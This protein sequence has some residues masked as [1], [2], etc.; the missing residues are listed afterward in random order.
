[1]QSVYSIVPTN[2]VGY[3][4]LLWNPT[5]GWGNLSWSIHCLLHWTLSI[6]DPFFYHLQWYSWEMGNFSALKEELSLWICNLPHSSHRIQRTQLS[7]FS[8]RFQ[9]VEDWVDWDVLRH[10]RR[11]NTNGNIYRGG[12]G[13]GHLL[14]LKC[15]SANFIA[16]IL[17]KHLDQVLMSAPILVH[18][19][20]TYC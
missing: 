1:M 3:N 20:M 16:P 19:S 13:W 14:I 11:Y 10:G 12:P 4:F 8:Y 5:F 7:H 18:P 9:V 15:F 17:L 2:R 6:K